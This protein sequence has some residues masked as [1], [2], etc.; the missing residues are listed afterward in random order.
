MSATLIDHA[1]LLRQHVGHGGNCSDDALVQAVNQALMIVWGRGEWK[2][3][4][5]WGVI[6]PR[7]A[8]CF[9][10][11]WEV[12]HVRAA[13]NCRTNIEVRD[14]WFQ[15]LPDAM[16]PC[17]C[18]SACQGLIPWQERVTAFDVPPLSR[19]HVSNETCDSDP[20][21]I[22]GTDPYGV[23]IRETVIGTGTTTSLFHKLTFVGKGATDGPIRLD[24]IKQ[25]GSRQ[26]L[27][28]YHPRQENP[29]FK[30]IMVKSCSSRALTIRYK[31]RF[32]PIRDTRDTLP[33]SNPNVLVFLLQALNHMGKDNQKF[34]ENLALAEEF[35]N[36]ELEEMKPDNGMPV[37]MMTGPSVGLPN[38]GCYYPGP[39]PDDFKFNSY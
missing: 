12:D 16:G 24:A 29:R 2:E 21:E 18:G 33:L 30:T 7:S 26:F 1:P 19:I 5:G 27:A 13:Y 25:D 38:P 22:Q 17:C 34:T 11:P 39:D 35:L 31:K 15:E 9:T 6:C 36:E 32:M 4:M 14:T 23:L 28:L 10:L 37:V 3:T 20:I 8:C